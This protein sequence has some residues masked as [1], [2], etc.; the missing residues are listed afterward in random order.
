MKLSIKG[1]WQPTPKIIRK[2]A[3]SL[4]ASAMLVASISFVNDYKTIAIVVLIVA[5]IS[6][7]FSNFFTK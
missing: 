2:I 6:K 3:D 7:F 4:L 1:Y 5:G